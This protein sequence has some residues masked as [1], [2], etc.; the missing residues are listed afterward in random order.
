MALK[1]I[2]LK[3]SNEATWAQPDTNAVEHAYRCVELYNGSPI[4]ICNVAVLDAFRLLMLRR[5]I[6]GLA[7]IWANSLRS[8][9]NEY[10]NFPDWDPSV[11]LDERIVERIILLQAA[12]R[13]KAVA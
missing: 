9:A 7:I 10:A 1:M 3:W 4:L 5:E 11:R 12:K 8:V 2:E 6:E 13:K